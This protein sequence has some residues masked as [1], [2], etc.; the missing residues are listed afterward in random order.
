MI[1]VSESELKVSESQKGRTHKAQ[2]NGNE[3]EQFKW[4]KKAGR[5]QQKKNCELHQ[6]ITIDIPENSTLFV[7]F[8]ETIKLDGIVDIIVKESNLYACQNGHEFETSG[9]GIGLCYVDK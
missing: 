4:S 9:N 5:Q 7:I 2:G 8:Q 1:W 3:E 6:E